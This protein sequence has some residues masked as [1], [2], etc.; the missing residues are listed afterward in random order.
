MFKVTF[1]LIH[2]EYLDKKHKKYLA[3]SHQ[4]KS[5]LCKS[6]TSQALESP[7]FTFFG[8]SLLSRTIQLS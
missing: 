8:L 5:L 2:F 6:E 7:S 3:L 4:T 1:C